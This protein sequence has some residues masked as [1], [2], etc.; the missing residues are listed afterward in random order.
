MKN[1]ANVMKFVIAVEMA[2]LFWLLP[3]KGAMD[4][5]TICLAQYAVFA[6]VDVSM[7]IKNIKGA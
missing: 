3:E 2:L 6:P 5:I 7:I 4:I 1:A